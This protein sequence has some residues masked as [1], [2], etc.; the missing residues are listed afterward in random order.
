MS[1]RASENENEYKRQSLDLLL[2]VEVNGKEQVLSSLF[3]PTHKHAHTHVQMCSRAPSCLCKCRSKMSPLCF[4][5]LVCAGKVTVFVGAE[6]QPSE[7]SLLQHVTHCMSPPAS[8][9]W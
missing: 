7:C 8:C 3:L 1:E 9:R 2:H 6:S 5:R 4:C